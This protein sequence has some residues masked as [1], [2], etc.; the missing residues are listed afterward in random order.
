LAPPCSCDACKNGCRYGS[1]FLVGDDIKNI[2]KFKSISEKELKENFLE[3]KELFNTILLRPKLITKGKPYGKCIFFDEEKGC[4]VHPVKP[5]QC[6]I[7]MGCKEYG[8]DLSLWFMLNHQVNPND[9]E[10]IRQYAIYLKTQRTLPGGSLKE[11]VPDKEKLKNMLN[12]N[13]L[14]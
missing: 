4:T 6:K 10:S 13:K 5:L 2:A 1:G 11:L 14:K 12:F 7:S 8:E 3:E 9:P